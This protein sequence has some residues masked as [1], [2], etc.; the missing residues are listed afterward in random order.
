MH[1]LNM[2]AKELSDMLCYAKEEED[3]ELEFSD[4]FEAPTLS[5]HVVHI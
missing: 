3:N 2:V 1:P 5:T 4:V